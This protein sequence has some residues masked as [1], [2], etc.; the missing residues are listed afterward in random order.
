MMKSPERR[1]LAH[2]LA[3]L[4][5]VVSACAHTTTEPRLLLNSERIE[6]T[7]GSYGVEILHATDRLRVSSLYSLEDG[8][9]VTRTFAVVRFPGSVDPRV[10]ET[11][12][13]IV[14][15]GS[16][17]ATLRA[18]GWRVSKQHLHLGEIEPMDDLK[19]VYALME[20]ETTPLAVDLYRLTATRNGVVVDYATLAELHHPDYL[21]VEALRAVYDPDR[22]RIVDSTSADVAS[23]IRAAA[24]VWPPD[25]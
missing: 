15:G 22:T 16:I 12:R 17:G 21:D 10:A 19:G 6:A 23:M 13:E 25:R 9:R 5:F 14:D 7:F 20:V 4:V 2:H 24:E 11:H 3:A 1:P 8:R 18:H